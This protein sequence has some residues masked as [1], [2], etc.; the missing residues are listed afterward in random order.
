M[1]EIELILKEFE[2]YFVADNIPDCIPKENWAEMRSEVEAFI[3][4][5]LKKTKKY[6]EINHKT[7]LFEVIEIERGYKYVCRLCG[8]DHQM[9]SN[10][11]SRVLDL[12]NEWANQHIELH[13]TLTTL[14]IE[15]EEV[16]PICDGGGKIWKDKASSERGDKPTYKC[17]RCKGI[18]I[19]E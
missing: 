11:M 1:K 6:G 4:K 5:I 18:E 9:A 14:G 12:L 16:C 15:I 8:K 17:P 2:D 13:K 7:D 10:D 3:F 19:E